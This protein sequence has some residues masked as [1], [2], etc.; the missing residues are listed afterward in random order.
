MIR[1]LRD[2]DVQVLRE[3]HAR[4]GYGF[5][6][7]KAEELKCALVI[8]DDGKVVGMAAA[9]LEAQIFGVFDPDFGTPGERLSLFCDLHRP[10]ADELDKLGAK[11]AYVALD[12]KFPA[13]GRRLMRFGWK[14]ALWPHYW[15]DV[16][17]CLMRF[18]GI[19]E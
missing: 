5:E 12:P 14:K 13:F 2:S 6:F 9:R 19:R 7:P 18:G 17:D 4:A 16:K 8:E 1:K 3:I 11:E 15:L 10:I